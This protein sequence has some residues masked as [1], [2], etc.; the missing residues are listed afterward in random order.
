MRQDHGVAL[1]FQ[2]RDLL[3]ERRDGPGRARR[4]HACV[5]LPCVVFD[6]L[7]AHVRSML[8]CGY[9]T[10]QYAAKLYS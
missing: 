8:P 3:G 4:L 10:L 1:L 6:D 2:L 9:L 5:G 7:L